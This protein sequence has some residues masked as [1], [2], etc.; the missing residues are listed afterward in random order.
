ML[1]WTALTVLA[2][3][4]V[5]GVRT[6]D[7]GKFNTKMNIGAA[8][9]TFTALPGVDGKKVSLSDFKQDVLVVAITCNKCPM[10]IAYEDRMIQFAK[11]YNSKVGFVAINV[12]TVEADKLEKMKERAESKGFN[13]PYVYDESQKIGRDLGATVTPEFFVFDKNRKLVYTGAF[14][15]AA[16]PDNVKKAY[17]E[18]AVKAALDGKTPEVT[19]TK[20]R[21]CGVA[22]N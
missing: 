22:Y 20:G 17:V 8:A 16:N 1:R 10:A 14:D 12:N 21:G 18:D 9:P 5:I 6:A 11:K 4:L 15:D 19:E 13:F 7:A 2:L 3:G